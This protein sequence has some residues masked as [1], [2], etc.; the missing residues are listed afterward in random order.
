VYDCLGD[1][2][3]RWPD[4]GIW[5]YDFLAVRRLRKCKRGVQKADVGTRAVVPAVACRW[6]AVPSINASLTFRSR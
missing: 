3:R 2:G 6:F 5:V 4:V 1:F